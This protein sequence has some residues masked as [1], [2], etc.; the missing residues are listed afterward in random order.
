[1]GRQ[2]L[3]VADGERPMVAMRP[4]KKNLELGRAWHGQP[5]I[6]VRIGGLRDG[7]VLPS[8]WPSEPAMGQLDSQRS[9]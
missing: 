7:G 8:T 4:C 1:M 3:A 2:K 9:S 5:R 6:G